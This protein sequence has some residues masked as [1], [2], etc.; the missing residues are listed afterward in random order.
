M[1]KLILFLLIAFVC[2]IL[3][4][5]K[6]PLV[7]DWIAKTLGIEWFNEFV[8]KFKSDIDSNATQWVSSEDLKNAYDNVMSGALEVKNTVQKTLDN[9]KERIDS[10]RI[11]LS[12]AEDTF[13]DMKDWYDAAIEILDTTNKKI[14]EVK[15]VIE[16][17]QNLSS[18]WSNQ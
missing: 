8:L 11:T 1:K 15:N 3:I 5:F 10:L 16:S 7:A 17:V 14:E 2:Y 9:T 12:W 18:S 4:I 13:N 6:A